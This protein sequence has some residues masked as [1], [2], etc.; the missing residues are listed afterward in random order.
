MV[1][2]IQELL[3]GQPSTPGEWIDAVRGGLRDPE[4][5]NP[6]LDLAS[7]SRSSMHLDLPGV[8]PEAA[9]LH[10]VLRG[11]EWSTT[12]GEGERAAAPE[13]PASSP[14]DSVPAAP[15][16]EGAAERMLRI[17]RR[18]ES[19]RE[20][21]GRPWF[22]LALGALE[23]ERA[24]GDTVL[25]P[26][27]L[28]PVSTRMDGVDGVT[29]RWEGR[30]VELNPALAG[31]VAPAELPEFRDASGRDEILDWYRTVAGAGAGRRWRALPRVVLGPF[32]WAR[33]AM[34]SDLDPVGWGE[35]L[36]ARSAASVAEPTEPERPVPWD[37][38][39]ALPADSS[40]AAVLAAAAAGGGVVVHARPGT[41]AT[42][43]AANLAAAC[44]ARG[45][46]VL[47]VSPKRATL[48]RLAGRLEV[49]GLGPA[50]L[51]LYGEAAH[52][53]G[54]LR[55]LRKEPPEGLEDESGRDGAVKE[56]REAVADLDRACRA[57]DGP[58]AGESL[59]A[60]EVV[61]LGVG[62][63]EVLEAHGVDPDDAPKLPPGALAGVEE[64]RDLLRRAE[65][66]RDALQAVWPIDSHPWR[67]AKSVDDSSEA[68]RRFV[69]A[70]E[71]AAAAAAVLDA[72]TKE[73]DVSMGFSGPLPA[74][75]LGDWRPVLDL[76]Q[77]A[78]A[79]LPRDWS[80]GNWV[81]PKAVARVLA[82]R[83]ETFQKRWRRGRAVFSDPG[84]M[85]V[86]SLLNE[87]RAWFAR[88]LRR[89]SGEYGRWRESLGVKE[90]A[91][92]GR[93][94]LRD[95]VR[96]L[97]N[98]EAA[99]TAQEWLEERRDEAATLYGE[100]W[101]GVASDHGEVAATLAWMD[102]WMEME[103][104]RRF[105]R[106]GSKGPSAEFLQSLPGR[107]S[108][109]FSWD[110]AEHRELSFIVKDLDEWEEISSTV[111]NHL[112]LVR[113]VAPEATWEDAAA[114]LEEWRGALD[115]LPGWAAWCRARAE[116]RGPA[117]VALE[118]VLDRKLSPEV[119][120]A[121]CESAAASAFSKEAGEKGAEGAAKRSA[122]A[123][124]RFLAAD[125][126]FLEAN[127]RCA[128]RAWWKGI[129]LA[130]R[131]IQEAEE[132]RVLQVERT[133]TRGHMPLVDLLSRA[134]NALRRT[135]P[136]ALATPAS[137]ARLL[138]RDAE[139]FDLVVVMGAERLR[140]VECLGAVIRA[141]Q[142]VAIGDPD[143]LGPNSLL[144]VEIEEEGDYRGEA[145]GAPADGWEPFLA[146]AAK[147]WP[148]LSLALDHRH[149][150]E[151]LVEPLAE[152]GEVSWAPVARPGARGTGLSV[153]TVPGGRWDPAE[154]AANRSEAARV[155]A[156]ALGW[157]GEND[158]GS[159]L[160]ATL[161]SSQR[162]AVQD[163]LDGALA[164]ADPELAARAR[165]GA[166]RVKVAET[167][168][169]DVAD[170]VFLS[171]GFGA[172]KGGV[173]PATLAPLAAHDGERRL[174][175][176]LAPARREARIYASF[177]PEDVPIDDGP[178]GVVALGRL[179]HYAL[180]RELVEA[181][182]ADRLMPFEAG[183]RR[184]LEGKGHAVRTGL[185][186]GL[187]AVDMAVVDPEDRGA[188]VVAVECDAGGAGEWPRDRLAIRPA[189]LE[190]RGW[191]VHR[192]W[193]N[194]W[195]KHP[196]ETRSALE[197]A[198][199][200][201]ARKSHGEGAVASEAFSGGLGVVTAPKRRAGAAAEGDPFS[202]V[203]TI[204]RYV[205]RAPTP[206]PVNNVAAA[207]ATLDEAVDLAVGI[208]GHEGP[209]HDA[210]L[211]RRLRECWETGPE[212][213]GLSELYLY[214]VVA[215]GV[216]RGV[217][218]QEGPFISAAGVPLTLHRRIKGRDF[219]DESQIPPALVRLARD[220]VAAEGDGL[221]D[222]EVL[223]GVARFFGY[224][225]LW[226]N[227][228]AALERAL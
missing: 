183:V 72:I 85:P 106:P 163:A 196:V 28:I 137:A 108:A 182:E 30:P 221:T 201:E 35:R 51:D 168:A 27:L 44:V 149:L 23:W 150:D 112:G 207:G 48:A 31:L 83:L 41:G 76:A 217:L 33:G 87:A 105:H 175:A 223:E 146:R 5:R 115:R 80:R 165:A 61:S 34:L 212:G 123:T 39:E 222:T 161:A 213:E 193:A 60:Y 206:A 186:R 189:A 36:P 58:A 131:G 198:V 200:R 136:V 125:D 211:R 195:W 162:E 102:E 84:G 117:G 219:E 43:T 45:G 50:V 38:T 55:H 22:H 66:L 90:G 13:W 170:A 156:D 140:T 100:S 181:P 153:V 220:H 1:R 227:V 226:P 92:K 111:C 127:R 151:S 107:L 194:D 3:A 188:F 177:R 15:W 172:G 133:K 197:T 155:V 118:W 141:G 56:L 114:R 74:E 214:A 199:D 109:L 19:A 132:D 138:P 185:G 88:R 134:G 70:L 176:A 29:L 171:V 79:S 228:R 218:A 139:P 174:A 77:R 135:C 9:Y 71:E 101:R 89:M 26:L 46:Q 142:V 53:V 192:V 57:V 42:Q 184:F 120:P 103:G 203:P 63:R 69:E 75:G 205:P 159:L 59:T 130:P 128:A 169:S 166:V 18:A 86:R 82:A 202:D 98:L 208:L 157:L 97:E 158:D 52:T 24:P 47:V 16:G 154:G 144:E 68:E 210:M 187:L 54:V 122:A 113:L 20:E 62:A 2:P 25:S 95:M 73:A 121:V 119:L 91:F 147:T 209:H 143:G 190:S 110:P 215:R 167:L 67:F 216:E 37:G 40:Q 81:G 104:G 14:A 64:V 178:A 164:G 204:A 179:M 129:P 10:L 99:L 4:V 148:T 180:T 152:A 224:R 78:P 116:A 94:R 17:H 7:F 173:A 160:I 191:A 11:G 145:T 124:R 93:W 6:F 126:A 65:G 96:E 12:A 225:A 8:L 49:A 32:D 21:T